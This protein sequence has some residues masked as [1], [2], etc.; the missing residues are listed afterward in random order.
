MNDLILQSSTFDEMQHVILAFADFFNYASSR[1]VNRATPF[2]W[3]ECRLL[4]K[5]FKNCRVS[6]FAKGS[7][8][9][10]CRTGLQ[11]VAV[12]LLTLAQRRTENR[13]LGGVGA[14][15]YRAGQ[16]T[17]HGYDQLFRN[18]YS[19]E[20]SNSNGGK[21]V[22]SSASSRETFLKK[23]SLVYILL[24]WPRQLFM[25]PIHN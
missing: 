3:S 23:Y 15:N 5:Q 8:A 24:Y 1:T 22:G 12:S 18:S 20:K 6:L 17:G 2:G 10:R 13:R 14:T 4:P 25:V 9:L 16:D 21:K 7:S 11:K 19:I